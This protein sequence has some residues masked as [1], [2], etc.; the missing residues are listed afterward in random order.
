MKTRLILIVGLSSLLLVAPA[1]RADVSTGPT[2]TSGS[3]GGGQGGGDGGEE[4]DD[5]GCSVGAAGERG[6]ALIG[7]ALALV[8]LAPLLRRRRPRRDGD[9]R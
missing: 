7:G 1:A 8:A 2:S 6:P 3:G 9:P 4:E 5:G